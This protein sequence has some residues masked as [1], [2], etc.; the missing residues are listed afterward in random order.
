MLLAGVTI[1][2]VVSFIQVRNKDDE[3]VWFAGGWGSRE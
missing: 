3:Y 2:M 1:L